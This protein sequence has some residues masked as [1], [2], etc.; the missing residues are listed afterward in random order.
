MATGTRPAGTKAKAARAV[1]E[2]PTGGAPPPGVPGWGWLAG[3]SP[4]KSKIKTGYIVM[5]T[6]IQHL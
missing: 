4:K 2:F 3:A 1:G 5:Q 6:F